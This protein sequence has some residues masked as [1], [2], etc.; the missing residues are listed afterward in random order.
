M[1]SPMSAAEVVTTIIAVIAISISI[2][3]LYNSCKTSKKMVDLEEIHAK[4]SKI[5]LQKYETEEKEKQKANLHVE[6]QSERGS[7][8]FLIENRGPASAKNIHFHITEKNDHNPLVGGDYEN[9][10][11]LPILNKGESYFF[12]ASFPINISQSIYEI[13]LRWTNADKSQE[14]RNYSLSR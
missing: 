14:S 13:S 10:T 6:L 11:P 8:K 2:I 1:A 12:L 5:Q 3:S 4:V 9:K 7:G